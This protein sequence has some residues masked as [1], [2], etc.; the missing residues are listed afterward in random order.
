MR[1]SSGAVITPDVA[2]PQLGQN[3]APVGIGWPHEAQTVVAM[4]ACYGARPLA[5]LGVDGHPPAD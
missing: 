4:V 2:K 3:R 5:S 1:R